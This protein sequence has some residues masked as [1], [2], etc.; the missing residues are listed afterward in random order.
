MFPKMS[1]VITH[2]QNA[3]EVCPDGKLNLSA[4][5]MSE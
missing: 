3:A 4:A 2:R 1:K 5:I